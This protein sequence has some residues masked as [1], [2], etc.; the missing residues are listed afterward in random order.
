M[1]ILVVED[2]LSEREVLKVLLEELG[3][4]VTFASN[5]DEAEYYANSMPDLVLVDI[6]LDGSDTNC[7]DGLTLVRK[8]RRQGHTF[9]I[10]MISKTNL[11]AVKVLALRSGADDYITKPYVGEEL[12]ARI[13]AILRRQKP[14][15]RDKVALEID[16][17]NFS[18][19]SEERNVPL[20]AKEF[21][22]IE[23]LL[24]RP[25]VVVSRD[26]LVRRVWSDNDDVSNRVIDNHIGA[27]RRK[28]E[29]VCEGAGSF[30]QTVHG[31][32]YKFSIVDKESK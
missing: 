1:H 27:L 4:S 14:T 2:E 29:Q 13:E 3:F 6:V 12:A 26:T 24:N 10:I 8:L 18:L 11:S 9:P 19:R 21:R 22:I 28:L 20:T 16:F 5:T 31:I 23:T 32:G 25:D 15:R 17:D 30:L 7:P